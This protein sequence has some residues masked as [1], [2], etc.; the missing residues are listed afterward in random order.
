MKS[1]SM[2]EIEDRIRRLGLYLPE[3]AKIPQGMR[4]PFDWVRAIGNRVFI[5]GHGPQNPDGSLT[6]P[7]GGKVGAELTLEEGYKASRL[8][9]LS[10][11]ASLKREID[12][13]DRIKAWL[14]VNGMVNVGRGFTQTTSVING[15]SDLILELYGPDGGRHART[16]I[17]VAMLP[18]NS[19]VI[20]S[21]EVQIS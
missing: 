2:A 13:L 18:L 15:F 12:D 7:V 11:L 4:L 21:G 20:I 17:G 16:A 5:S 19:P 3:P 9:A 14:I 10:I 1:D 8:T 6:Y